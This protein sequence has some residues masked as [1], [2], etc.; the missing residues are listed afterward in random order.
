[1]IEKYKHVIWDW[2]GTILN[3]VELSHSILNELL[4]E[5]NIRT[6]TVDEYREVFSMPVEEY[7][8]NVGFD[9]S[10]ESFEVLG[11]KWIDGY[12]SRKYG[13]ALYEGI[14]PILQ[15]INDMNIRQSI[16]SAYSDDVL[17]ELVGHYKLTDY[18]THIQG[19]DNIYAASKIALGKNLIK[20]IGVNKGEALMIGDT[21]HDYEVAKEIGADCIL[22]ANGHQ[23]R[24]KLEAGIAKNNDV[25]IISFAE[26]IFN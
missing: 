18:F 25:K 17:N 19:L 22:I 24:Q 23:S 1:M 26:D 16:L 6:I 9:F 13:C 8:K 5:Y 20:K 21:L 10:V 15:K 7:Y 12:E 3:D 2:N 11:K 14:E 4:A